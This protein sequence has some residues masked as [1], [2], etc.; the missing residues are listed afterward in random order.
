MLESWMPMIPG[1]KQIQRKYDFRNS[2]HSGQLSSDF[3]SYLKWY[4]GRKKAVKF[5]YGNT[6]TEQAYVCLCLSFCIKDH[7]LFTL[8]SKGCWLLLCGISS[9]W[10]RL[11]ISTNICFV[12]I[13]QWQHDSEWD[14]KHKLQT[15]RVPFEKPLPPTGC[16]H[17]PKIQA[18][19]SQ[20]QWDNTWMWD[21][22]EVISINVGH[23]VEPCGT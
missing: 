4:W 5:F 7:L 2:E 23:R 8:V 19:E 17:V 3:Y 1:S 18:C 6:S 10:P 15:S 14:E 16:L 11:F 9:E 22:W 20:S 21:Y 13:N 12:M